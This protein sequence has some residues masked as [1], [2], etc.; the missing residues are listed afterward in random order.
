MRIERM[1]WPGAA[2]LAAACLAAGC[3]YVKPM[4]PKLRQAV[5]GRDTIYVLPP[6]AEYRVKG[7]F[8]SPVDAERSRRIGEAAGQLLAE[9]A[10]KVFPSATVLRV[11]GS[12]AERVLAEAAGA[13]VI[14]CEVK[15]FHRT[16]PREIVSEAL[17]VLLMVP[18]FSL[19]LGYPVQTT[20]NIYLKVRRPGAAKSV[21]LTHRD[22]ADAYDER[23]LRF[24]IRILLDPDY[25][26][27][28]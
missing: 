27:R 11:A 12:D 6:R 26:E 17:N 16:L 21:K 5:A 25:Q 19:S 24:Q 10:G 13:T 15:G 9:E 22:N 2:V 3:T 14:A 4:S 7:F 20:S 1:R 8:A 18:T 28:T 23:D